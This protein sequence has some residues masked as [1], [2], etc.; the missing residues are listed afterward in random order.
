MDEKN[1]NV[2]KYAI[3][4]AIL[5]FGVHRLEAQQ[6][7]LTSAKLLIGIEERV[8]D[9]ISGQIRL[10]SERGEEVNL[11]SLI[12]KPTI[13]ALVYYR[14][15]GVC[16]PLM[17]GLAEV[18]KLSDMA[19]GRDYQILTVSFNPAEGTEL[20][21]RKKRNY[22]NVLKLEGAEEGWLF[23][24]A[25]SLQIQRLTDNVGFRYQKAG[26]DYTHVATLIFISPDGKITRY[27][28]GVRFLPFE[29]KLAILETSKGIPGPSL[30][31]V[32]QYCYSYDPHGQHY[33]LS[34]TRVAGSIISFFLVILF[35]FL[36]LRRVPRKANR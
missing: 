16:T 2:V 27:L 8:G 4:A 5:L 35:L 14:C 26:N 21:S 30:N 24:T 11:R 22:M 9:S 1:S 10:R 13:L 7:P 19:I 36:A 28:N 34:V 25:D 3:Y 33:V 20:A 29:F 31:K 23:F 18:V 15:P 12:T 32:L 6:L 17:D